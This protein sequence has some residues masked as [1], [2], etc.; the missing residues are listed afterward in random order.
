[1]ET[2]KAFLRALLPR[3]VWQTLSRAKR[4]LLRV[5][6]KTFALKHDWIVSCFTARELNDLGLNISPISDYYSPL[7]IVSELERKRERWFKPSE[8]V[9][10]E[11]NIDQMKEMVAELIDKYATEYKSLPPYNEVRLRGYGEGFTPVDALVL[12]SMIREIQPRHYI[13]VGAGISTYYGAM[14]A[15]RNAEMGRAV[16]MSAIDP[17]PKPMLKTVPNVTILEKAV[18][19][20]PLSLFEDL[21]DG[22]ILFIDSTH[23]VKIDGD[24]PFLYLE[25]LPRLKS[26]VFVHIHDVSFP[27]NVPYPAR[28][29]I[30]ERDWPFF[31]TEAMLVQAMLCHSQAYEMVLSLPMI[32]HVDEDFLQATLPDYG[33]MTQNP[34]DTFSSLWIRKIA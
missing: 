22:D 19:D 28:T 23:T 8:L 34:N 13:E 5:L 1:M 7:P 30:F 6:L 33:W 25:V 26:G 17:Y 31:W 15:L 12:Y 3:V 27:Y 21:Q 18:Q 2:I 29:W 32:R 4:L 9:G 24:C 16:Q 20:V 10:V 11:Y 14:A